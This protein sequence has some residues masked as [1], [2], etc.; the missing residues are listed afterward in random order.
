MQGSDPGY[1]ALLRECLAATD[2]ERRVHLYGQL[3]A[4]ALAPI[5]EPW[6]PG[7]T[8][9]ALDARD[10]GPGDVDTALEFWESLFVTT[11]DPKGL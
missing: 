2:R 4:A 7:L 9:V 11:P 5:G 1:L 10:Y 6:Q 8:A 3:V